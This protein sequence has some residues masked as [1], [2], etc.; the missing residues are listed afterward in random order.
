MNVKAGTIIRTV[1]LVFALVNQLL[2]ATGRNPLPFSEEEVYQS[3]S[4]VLSAVTAIVAWW[5]NNSFSKEALLADEYKD[6]LKKEK[7]YGN[8]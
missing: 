6:S 4:A 3:F 2:T 1:V 7:N 5:K 8:D